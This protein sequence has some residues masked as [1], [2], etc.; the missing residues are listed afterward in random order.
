MNDMDEKQFQETLGRVLV[1][2][3]TFFQAKL[4]MQEH[5]QREMIDLIRTTAQQCDE[6]LRASLSAAGIRLIERPI[7]FPSAELDTATIVKGAQARGRASIGEIF[8]MNGLEFSS[9][10]SGAVIEMDL[11]D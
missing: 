6:D 8:K 3:F 5:L 1:D 4:E 11:S 2:C 9:T 10:A 7:E